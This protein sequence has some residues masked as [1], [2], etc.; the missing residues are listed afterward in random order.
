MYCHEGGCYIELR[1]SDISVGCCLQSIQYGLNVGCL[2]SMG[3]DELSPADAF[4]LGGPLSLRG[5]NFRA[6]GPKRGDNF[7]GAK[8]I[9]FF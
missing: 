7:V 2:N 3:D 6:V 4:Y 5:F 9:I 8:V 1:Q